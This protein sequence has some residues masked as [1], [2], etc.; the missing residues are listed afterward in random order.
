MAPPHAGERRGT[1]PAYQRAGARKGG[2]LHRSSDGG[3]IRPLLLKCNAVTGGRMR[4]VI[5]T[6]SLVSDWN[7]GNAHFLRGVASELVSRGNQ[8][9]IY[10]PRDGWSYRNLVERQGLAA[11][12]DFEAAFP[13]FAQHV[14]RC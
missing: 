3:R 1:T 5:F 9:T 4:I 2:T 6:H 12:R 14:L 7:H 8:V 13:K 10:E 11:V